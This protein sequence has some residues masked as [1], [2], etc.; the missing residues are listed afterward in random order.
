MIARRRHVSLAS[1]LPD[2]ESRTRGLVYQ[3]PGWVGKVNQTAFSGRRQ[4]RGVLPGIY[5]AVKLVNVSA[6]SCLALQLFCRLLEG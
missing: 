2:P 6:F 1:Q 4:N 5:L 3:I